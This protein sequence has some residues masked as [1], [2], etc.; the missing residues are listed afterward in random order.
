MAFRAINKV[1]AAAVGDDLYV[2]RVM[3]PSWRVRVRRGPVLRGFLAMNPE[4][5]RRALATIGGGGRVVLTLGSGACGVRPMQLGMS[6][7]AAARSEV[8]RSIGRLFPLEPEEAAVGLIERAPAGEGSGAA[9]GAAAGAEGESAERGYLVVAPRRDVEAWTEALGRALGRE[10]SEV[11]ATPMAM[12]GLGLQH[13]E[14]VG[15]IEQSAAGGEE[16][17]W[18]RYGVI[19]ELGAAWSSE[20]DDAAEVG[21]VTLRRL[22]EPGGH[23]RAAGP[24]PGVE[25]I[26]GFDLAIG[27]ALATRVAGG[28][29]APILGR[30]TGAQKRW[31]L[32]LGAAAA[33]ALLLWASGTVM[34]GRY[35]RATEHL[36][37]EG[38]SM[39]DDLAR[40]QAMRTELDAKISLVENG[41]GKTVA[42]WKSVLPDLTSIHAVVPAQG[43]IYEVGVDERRVFLRG[44]APRASDVLR[45]LESSAA[46]ESPKQQSPVRAV[47]ERSAEE[48]DLVATRRAGAV[49]KSGSGGAVGAG[50][51]PKE[52]GTSR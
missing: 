37:A 13:E 49:A 10:V 6:R 19:E 8:I 14:R 28:R 16:I 23:E 45:A 5:A 31:I 35:E 52:G 40:V 1:S 21:G 41:V 50:G 22:P 44:E 24:T 43:F 32:P 29:F 9:L 27:A 47:D 20:M 39:A 42:G 3:G 2:V 36:R 48:F 18:L 34:E 51:A 7:W 12:L 38:A 46:F 4:E 30:A 26:D 33:A 25:Q 11:L 17:H 15:I